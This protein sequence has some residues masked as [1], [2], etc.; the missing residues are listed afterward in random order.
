M[1]WTKNDEGYTATGVNGVYIARRL[2]GKFALDEG[3]FVGTLAAVKERAEALDVERGQKAAALAFIVVNAN[4][5][6][7][8]DGKTTLAAGTCRS[9]RIARRRAKRALLTLKRAV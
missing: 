5:W 4:C 3:R 1:K 9:R 7:I 8:S 2:K 6:T